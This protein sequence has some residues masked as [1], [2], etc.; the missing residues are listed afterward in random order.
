MNRYLMRGLMAVAWVVACTAHGCTPTSTTDVTDVSGD[1]PSVAITADAEEDPPISVCDWAQSGDLL[2]VGDI[3][4]VRLENRPVVGSRWIDGKEDLTPR[5]TC[6]GVV[7]GALAIDL[8]RTTTLWSAEDLKE[9]DITVYVGRD[10]WAMFNPMPVEQKADGSIVWQDANY[11]DV[12]QGLK[13]G[14]RVGLL[15]RAVKGMGPDGEP[16]ETT[17]WSVLGEPMFVIDEENRV[18][19]QKHTEETGQ[20]G[21]IDV[22]DLRWNDFIDALK[23]CGDVSETA[24]KRRA[25]MDR[26]WGPASGRASAYRAGMCFE[27]ED[28]SASRE[29]E[30]AT[31]CPAGTRCH[32][33]RCE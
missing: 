20:S 12:G 15:A 29:C 10:R 1:L 30:A 19:F 7:E 3:S 2:I 6:D 21:P 28:P 27:K 18:V 26:M 14:Q 16:L 23:N 4:A 31:D 5:G 32:D 24:V 33:G 22:K 25:T 13:I 17:Q 8:N 9:H 11:G